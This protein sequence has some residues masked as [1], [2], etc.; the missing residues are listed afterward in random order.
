LLF[1]E[2]V[3]RDTKFTQALQKLGKIYE[4]LLLLF[5]AIVEYSVASVWFNGAFGIASHA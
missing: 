4:I 5:E 1:K 3:R 2:S